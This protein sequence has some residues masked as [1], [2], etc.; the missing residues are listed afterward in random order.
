MNTDKI[1]N[2][3]FC[4]CTQI[5]KDKGALPFFILI[6]TFLFSLAVY[7]EAQTINLKSLI[8]KPETYDGKMVSFEA[9]AIGDPLRGKKGSWFNVQSG[10]YNMGIFVK[11]QSIINSINYWGNYK[12][13][14]DLIK[15]KGIFYK[16]CSVHGGRDLHLVDLEVVEKGKK[17]KLKVADG[18]KRFALF[19]F[20]IF[21]T[22]GSIYLIKIRLWQQK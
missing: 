15:I 21:L 16:N 13:R 7:A 14:G 22:L 4:R 8:A 11:N 20:V 19:S 2:N 10:E 6:L 5:W 18:K 17:I 9:E 12:E 1:L 3:S